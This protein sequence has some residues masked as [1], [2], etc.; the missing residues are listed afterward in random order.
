LVYTKEKLSVAFSLD[1]LPIIYIML[2]KVFYQ[3]L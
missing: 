1:Y 3:T 2:N